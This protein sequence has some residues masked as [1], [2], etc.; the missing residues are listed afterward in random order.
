[1]GLSPRTFVTADTHFGDEG[2]IARFDR[3]F[4][5]V[6]EMDDA[7]VHGINEVVGPDDRLYHLGDFVGP[8]SGATTQTRHA[9]AIRERIQCRN[10]ILVR[11]NKD[12]RLAPEFDRLFDEV[13]DLLSFRGWS[14]SAG[15]KAPER[16]VMSHYAFRVWQGRAGGSLHLH[17]HSHGT[18]EEAGRSTD[19]GVDCWGYRPRALAEILELLAGREIDMDR[20][21]G[22]RQPNR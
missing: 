1:M 21:T 15:T 14:T 19:V 20:M 8:V 18:L 3:P 12:P 2:A 17:G 4:G 22:R 13:H 10:I 7:L 9:L 16:V 6:D 5:S 11:G